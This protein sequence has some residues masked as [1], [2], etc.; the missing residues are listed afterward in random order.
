MTLGTSESTNLVMG[1]V[2]SA[3]LIAVGLV[4]LS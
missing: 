1:T 3:G 2:I 4:S